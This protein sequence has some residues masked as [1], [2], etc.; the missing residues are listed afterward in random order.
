MAERGVRGMVEIASVVGPLACLDESSDAGTRTL[1]HPVWSC[2]T[3]ITAMIQ[4]R[5]K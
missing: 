1:Q 2:G 4:R 5:D 3:H